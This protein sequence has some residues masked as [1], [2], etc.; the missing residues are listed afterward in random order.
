MPVWRRERGAVSCGPPTGIATNGFEHAH[1]GEAA[2]QDTGERLLDLFVGC[3]RIAIENGLRCQ[4]DAAQAEPA[5]GCLLVDE[6][7]L[8]R[9]WLVGG[10]ESFECRDLVRA[11]GAHRRHAR[12]GGLAVDDH[13]ARSALAEAAAEFR[14]SK[15]EI[16]A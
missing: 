4:D 2:A 1:V 3:A 12:P 8:Q 16:I 14:A 11:D 5:L 9:V 6:C 13:R 10:P 7:L 15:L